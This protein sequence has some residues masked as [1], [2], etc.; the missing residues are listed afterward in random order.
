MFNN[1]LNSGIIRYQATNYLKENPMFEPYLVYQKG[2][3]KNDKFQVATEKSLKT[4]LD[5][6]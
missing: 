5:L 2:Y 6:L 3:G 4:V 1:N